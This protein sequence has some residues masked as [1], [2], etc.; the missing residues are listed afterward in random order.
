M[1]TK[2]IHGSWKDGLELGIEYDLIY[3]DPPFFTQKRH[4][5][6]KEG[7][8]EDG[9]LLTEDT[10]FD[11]IWESEDEYMDWLCNVFVS[12]F[13][14]LKRTGTIYSHNNFHI[15]GMLYGKLP[16]NVKKNYS[17]NISWQRSG[18]HNNVK[19]GFGN[20]VDSIMV[21]NKSKDNYFEVQYQPLNKKYEENSF[22]KKDEVGNF[23]LIGV[24]GEKSRVGHFYT[25]KGMCPKYG[26]RY[27]LE[28]I[29]AY[30]EKNELY[31]GKN[32]PYRKQYLERCKGVPIQNIWTDIFYITRSVKN[33]REYPTQKPVKLLDRIIKCSCPKG[34]SVLDPFCGSGTTAL[35]ALINDIP[36]LVVLTDRNPEAIEITN[37]QIQQFHEGDRF[38][39]E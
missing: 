24:S 33:K 37:L 5:M 7:Y 31:I 22:K 27:K 36:D 13:N 18:P 3:L 19:K 29:I 9:N 21:F 39:M 30:D 25:Y 15:N 26:W 35:S 1:E 8:D 17:T 16:A 32:K 23:A 4:K 14:K 11:D 12:C 20:I 6:N 38:G 10:H 28:D 2:V 34:G